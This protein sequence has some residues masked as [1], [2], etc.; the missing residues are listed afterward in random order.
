ME[1]EDAPGPACECPERFHPSKA[2]ISAYLSI[3]I[4]LG[5][6]YFLLRSLIW[7]ENARWHILIES[8]YIAVLAGLL[9]HLY[10][11]FR[12]LAEDAEKLSQSNLALCRETVEH[13]YTRESLQRSAR[14]L[15]ERLRELYC[16]YGVAN[17]IGNHRTSLEQALHIPAD[18]IPVGT[19]TG[20]AQIRLE[21]ILREI[22]KL[23]PSA[24]QY[25]EIACARLTV[26]KQVVKTENFRETAWKQSDAITVF[27]EKRGRVEIC[28][29]KER[30]QRDEGPFLKKE[31]NLLATIAKQI[32]NIVEQA[33]AE[34]E[35]RQYH[36]Q[37]EKRV[38]E[39]T[40]AMKKANESLQKEIAT[41]KQ[42][43]AALQKYTE[44]LEEMVQERTN[45][46]RVSQEEL[47][48]AE[49]HA[50]LGRLAAGIAHEI[51]NFL[52]VIGSSAYYLDIK[53]DNADT[54]VLQHLRR[55]QNQVK[56]A[57]EIIQNLQDLTSMKSPKKTDIDLIDAV[58][59]GIKLAEMPRQISLIRN[60]PEGKALVKADKARLALLFKNLALNA[61]QAMNGKGVLKVTT[62]KNGALWEVSVKDSGPGIP[63]QDLNR[64]FQPFFSTK[65]NGTGFGLAVCEIIAERHG[66]TI[67]AHSETG[68]GATF[69][70]RIPHYEL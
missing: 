43:E 45:E 46:L 29:L 42:A 9:I 37:L 70:V 13:K 52:G 17:L 14:E 34:K 12:R 3:W 16:L 66:G 2:G 63:R 69:V 20:I 19:K 1:S 56:H 27:G 58:E 39:R 30:P 10:T 7:Q 67:S 62:A 41:R 51:R 6:G 35:L 4:A 61:A 48:R 24:W 33:H 31:R 57:T 21:P 28:Y 47:V 64:I 25:P 44:N 40:A 5:A 50:V 68:E 59:T 15:E 65:A 22:A 8:V 26:E 23:I 11:R 38:D 54:K 55:I 32:G 18:L 53:L 60:L 49:R 36:R